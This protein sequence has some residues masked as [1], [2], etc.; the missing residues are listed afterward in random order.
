[1]KL[2]RRALIPLAV[3]AVS[4]AILMYFGLGSKRAARHE[5]LPEYEASPVELGPGRDAPFEIDAMPKAPVA[6]KVIAFAFAFAE[7]DAEPNAVDAKVEIGPDGAV[8]LKGRARALEGA[9]EVRIVIGAAADFTRYE[10]ALS[11]ARAG[12]SDGEVRVLVVPIMRFA[13]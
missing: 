2:G 10:D 11:A 8:R 9:R 3:L 13:H 1:M 12:S 6:L 5:A 4:A 7:G